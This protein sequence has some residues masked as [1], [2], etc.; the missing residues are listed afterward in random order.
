MIERALHTILTSGLTYLRDNP[1][2]LT[3]FFEADS[4]LDEGEAAEVE[5]WFMDAVAS[6]LGDKKH[7]PVVLGYPHKE[8]AKPPVMC[9]VLAQ[10]AETTQ[11]LGDE[12]GYIGQGTPD[13]GTDSYFAMSA[14]V[15]RILVYAELPDPALY[16]YQIAKQCLINGFPVLK[17]DPYFL[18]DLKWSGADVAPDQAYAPAG[19]YLRQLTLSSSRECI[20]DW[21]SSKVGR[22]WKVRGIHVDSAGAPGEAVGDVLT[23]VTVPDEG[24]DG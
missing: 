22:A 16:L 23:Q 21:P 5:E 8:T 11:V 14:L 3:E 1:G 15:H 9:I 18:S 13:E 20:Q 24:E 10:D 6:R 17:A 7:P 2:K 4:L 12:G 19:L